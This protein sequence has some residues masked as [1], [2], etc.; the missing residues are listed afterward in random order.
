MNLNKKIQNKESEFL[1]LAVHRLQTPLAAIAWYAEMLLTEDLEKITDSQKEYIEKIIASN[2]Q[3][4]KL[5][6]E[7]V[8]S[9]IY[10][11]NIQIKIGPVN[12]INLIK[13]VLTNF[14]TQIKSK[15]LKIVEKYI[16]ECVINS[17]LALLNVIFQNLI[18]NAIKYSKAKGEVSLFAT[19][20]DDI[21]IFE[22]KDSGIGI[23]DSQQDKLFTKLFRADNAKQ[24]E[25]EGTGL[26]LYG[27]KK[28]V[29]K[30]GGEIVIESKEGEGSLFRVELDIE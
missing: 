15:E 26:G 8:E 27:V 25:I 24:A 12:V 3:V 14:E 4:M 5:V 1:S 13:S 11:E 23:T 17:D 16:G 28:L 6:K 20:E 29:D 30:L 9:S 10:D 2:R 19:I 18:S 7:L 22:C 21:F